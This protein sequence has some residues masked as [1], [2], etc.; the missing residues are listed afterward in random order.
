MGARGEVRICAS[1]TSISGTLPEELQAFVSRYPLVRIYL[2][3][4]RS[5]HVV[6]SV[7]NGDADIGIFSSNVPA[8]DLEV[9]PYR[10]VDLVVIAPLNHPLSKRRSIA[11]A[12]T[13]EFDYIGLSDASSIGARVAS[14]AAE[15][16]ISIKTKMQVTTHGALCRVVQ[17]GMGIG[18]LPKYS[19]VPYSKLLNIRCLRT[20]DGWAYH[21]LSLC[22]RKVETL[23]MSARLLL[24]HLQSKAPSARTQPR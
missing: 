19:A 15:L 10:K 6:E 2:D 3:E 23:S 4:R 20:T 7:A 14:A 16:G 13:A 21:H 8:A 12:D 17:A 24:A 22:T 11:F 18:I 9:F 5:A 1:P